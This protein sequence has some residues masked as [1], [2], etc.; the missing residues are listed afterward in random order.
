MG[1]AFCA[2][3]LMKDGE[4]LEA[5]PWVAEA[6]VRRALPNNIE[7]EIAERAPIAFLRQGSDLALV[8]IHGVILERPLKA[9]FHFPV[10]TGIHEDMTSVERERRMRLFAGFFAASGIRRVRARWNK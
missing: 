10:V 1:G 5:I 8:D 4:Q 6:I 3:R 9:D 2:F 7:V